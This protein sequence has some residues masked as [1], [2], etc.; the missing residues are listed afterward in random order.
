MAMSERAWTR[1]CVLLGLFAVA[2]C[3]LYILQYT[4]FPYEPYR[5][6]IFGYLLRIQDLPAA[7]LVG[8]IVLA[9]ALPRLSRP[10]LALVAAIGERPWVSAAI[11]FVSLCIAQM[12][13]AKNH[14]LAGDE[15]LILMQAKAFA[16]G[17]LTPQFPPELVTW[18][19]PWPYVN[20][21]LFASVHTGKVVSVYWPGFALLLAPF[22]LLGIAGVCNAALT[23][24][25][26]LLIAALA[27]RLIG[28]PAAAGWAL[29]LALAS[30]AFTGMALGYFSMPA[31]LFLN[32]LF[33]W[34]LLERTP[35][36]LFL[37][38]AVGSL[39]LIL[40]NPMPHVL[41]A[42]PWI[43]WIAWREGRGALLRLAAGYAP[44]TLIGG[45]GWWLLMRQVQGHLWYAPYPADA[46][47]GHW[48]GNFLFHWHLQFDRVFVE[49]DAATLANRTAEFAK[50]W[51]WTVPGLP[52]VA[53]IGGWLARR[54][55]HLRLL[56]L[57]FAAMLAGYL[58]VRF[59]QGY[60]WGVRYLHPALGALPILGAAAIARLRNGELLG[61]LPRYA[62]SAALLS[63]ALATP[64][65]AWQIHAFMEDQLSRR[66][67][68]DEGVP[69]AVFV[70]LKWDYYTQDFVQNDP[71]LRDPVVFL[72]S[73]GRRED[74]ALLRE[75]FPPATLVRAGPYG[76]VWRL[77]AP[78]AARNDQ[79]PAK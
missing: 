8:F 10:G 73:R 78:L 7:A 21:W 55:A 74:E 70:T 43:F 61:V 18:V 31:H 72:L 76:H 37:A 47:P 59:D 33:A 53:L 14:P 19:V 62:A 48:F 32:L 20:L 42:L 9:A 11:A 2:L 15:Y 36:R 45:V 28:S 13:V 39:A 49:P 57:S 50:L 46:E 68:F 6:F 16:A 1:L 75:R 24:G 35:R 30:P 77:E 34:L 5:L 63:L 44:L 38:G 65:R 4:R 52:A 54:D 27:R 66:P 71:F 29:L 17:R 64:L 51:L 69:Q 41:F 26:F 56:G 23:S 79:R 67:A 3:T 25:S 60:G 12:L 22:A 40:N 58:F